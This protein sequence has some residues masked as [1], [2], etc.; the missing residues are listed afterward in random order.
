MKKWVVYLLGILTGVVLTVAGISL[1]AY[2]NNVQSD[3]G[4]TNNAQSDDGK[5]NNAKSYDGITYFEKPGKI[6]EDKAFQV[7]QVIYE[8]AA[9]VNAQSDEDNDLYFGKVYL[10][11]NDEGE[12]YYDEQKITAPAGKVFRQVGIYRYP[13]KRNDIKTVPVIQLMDK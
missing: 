9:L 13:T 12:Y 1:F 10:L 5:T 2:I 8:N 3:D 11:V 7:L 6:A 4:V